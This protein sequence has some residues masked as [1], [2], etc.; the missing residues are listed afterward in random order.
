MIIS[1][2]V[3]VTCSVFVALLL[4][5]IEQQL[6]AWTSWVG[7]AV[8]SAFISWII[9]ILLMDTTWDYG[10][11]DDVIVGTIYPFLFFKP[12]VKLIG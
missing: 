12:W 8:V 1:L 7:F 3:C 2:L 11:I 10:V 9:V 4:R 6:S 5:A